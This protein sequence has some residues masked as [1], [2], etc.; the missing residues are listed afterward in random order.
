M[1]CEVEFT[2]EFEIWWDNL[3]PDEQESVAFSIKILIDQGVNLKRPHAD[4]I[5][6]S[7]FTN[8]RE[9]R[10][11]TKVAPIGFSTPSIQ[12]VSQCC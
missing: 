6:G 12:D 8:M 1:A 5:H 10:A 7:K 3:T 4:T 9:L 11:S 2:D